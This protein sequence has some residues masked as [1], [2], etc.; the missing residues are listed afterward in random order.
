MKNKV[1]T[2]CLSA[3]LLTFI[4]T[5]LRCVSLS[6]FYDDAIGYFNPSFVTT[7]MNALYL[8]SSLWYLSAL[9]L[10]PKSSLQTE[11][12][13]A[14]VSIKSA[15]MFAAVLFVFSA[16]SIF[17]TVSTS[18]FGLI[19][20]L[21]ALASALFFSLITI[22]SKI[23]E[24]IRAFASIALISTLIIVLASLYFDMFIA[25]NSPHKILGSFTLMAAMVMVLCET[26]VYLCKPLTRLHLASALLT[27]SLGISF[28]LSSVIYLFTAS[29]SAFVTKPMILGNIGYLGIIVGISVYAVARCFTFVDATEKAET[30]GF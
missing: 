16:V 11:F 19:G 18:K 9:L 3:L 22:K 20:A 8:L 23:S 15:A 13:P 6:A 30:C 29:P 4:L 1:K 24:T 14:D 28:A 2:Y 7:V 27:F 5:L 21:T 25:M 10:I 17:A 26:R 12:S